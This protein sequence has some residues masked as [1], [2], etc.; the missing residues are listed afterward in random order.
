M[1]LRRP[2]G[3]VS[4]NVIES[5]SKYFSVLLLV[6]FQFCVPLDGDDRLLTSQVLF[7][8]PVQTRFFAAPGHV[9]IRFVLV[10]ANENV[11]RVVAE[12]GTKVKLC[13][14]PTVT[15]P[16]VNNG[17]VP[18]CGTLLK[19]GVIVV[20]PAAAKFAFPATEM[21]SRFVVLKKPHGK[22]GG[23][24]NQRIESQRADIGIRISQTWPNCGTGVQRYVAELSS[25]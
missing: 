2:A 3:A 12:G 19:V 25:I 13:P 21:K 7:T 9:Q 23:V 4:S 18:A 22:I 10:V 17:Y 11:K 8:P 16:A 20:I 5:R 6:S 1:T 15:L 24:D 14:A